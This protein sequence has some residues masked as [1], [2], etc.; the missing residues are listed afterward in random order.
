LPLF[1][2]CSA[3]IH[4]PGLVVA[5]RIICCFK[6]YPVLKMKALG[7]LETLKQRYML[8]CP[9]IPVLSRP[10][11]KHSLRFITMFTEAQD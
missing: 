3:F 6:A 7:S 9:L 10:Q 11:F 4:L 8:S 2:E 5:R 1:E